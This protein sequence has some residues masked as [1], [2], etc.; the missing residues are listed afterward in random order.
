M[1]SLGTELGKK[2]VEKMRSIEVFDPISGTWEPLL[3]SIEIGPVAND[4][5]VFLLRY[6][7]VTTLAGFLNVRHLACQLPRR[8]SNRRI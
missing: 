3:W 6:D 7:G 4:L 2:G 5:D 1:S 8:S